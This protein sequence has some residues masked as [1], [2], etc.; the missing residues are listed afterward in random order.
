MTDPVTVERDGHVL[1]IGVNPRAQRNAFDLAVIEALSGASSA[2]P[3]KTTGHPV[4][5]ALVRCWAGGPG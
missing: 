5:F 3:D 1:L 4:T 2:G